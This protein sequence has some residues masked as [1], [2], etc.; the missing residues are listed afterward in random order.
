[1]LSGDAPA[2][3]RGLIEDAVKLLLSSVP[4][5]WAR[6]YGEFEPSSQPPVAAAS[7]TKTEGQSQ[8]LAVSSG[9]LSMLA[10]HQRIAVA[11]GL[12]WRHLVIDCYSDGRLSAWTET[13]PMRFA[14]PPSG[15]A[16]GPS[17]RWPRRVLAAITAGCLI[18]AAV[19][20]TVGWRW[21]PPPR[22]GMIAVP[23][24]PPRQQE[25]FDVVSRY[26]DAENHVNGE[27]MAALTCAH[28]SPIIAL[29]N[30][31][32]KGSD[33]GPATSY[34][35]PDA[36]TSFSDDGPQVKA[37]VAFR[38]RPLNDRERHRLQDSGVNGGFV[39]LNITLVDEGGHLK[40]CYIDRVT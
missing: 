31:S 34:F 37:R 15:P 11:A 23:P 5:G 17:R 10:D 19:V 33:G 21:G 14:D 40:V 24:P 25:A 13:G 30:L 27:G 12:P 38:V 8:P 18:A 9:V 35:Y 16:S 29:L 32:N 22:V 1:M 28:P 39:S 3:D 36:V 4:A 7:V 2:N 6:L 26:F 20:F